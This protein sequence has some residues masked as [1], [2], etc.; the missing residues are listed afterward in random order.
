MFFLQRNLSSY[1]HMLKDDAFW[2]RTPFQRL[3]N[4]SN[5]RLKV[6]PYFVITKGSEKGCDVDR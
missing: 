5:N 2:S 1:S 4:F 6:I 3:L